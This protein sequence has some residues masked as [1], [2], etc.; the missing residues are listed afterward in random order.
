M[1]KPIKQAPSANE[2]HQRAH[3]SVIESA[4]ENALPQ[5][6]SADAA[7]VSSFPTAAQISEF[8]SEMGKK[9]GKIGGKRRLETM[10][11][12]DRSA[13]ASKAA[14]ARWERVHELD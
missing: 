8:M 5:P 14:R 9:G 13:V 11:A 1:L 3:Q 2:A 12:E 10:T 4:Q 7:N 6:S